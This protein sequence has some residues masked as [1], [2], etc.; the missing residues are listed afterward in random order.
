MRLQDLRAYKSKLSLTAYAVARRLIH[1]FSLSQV[2]TA[3]GIGETEL[4]QLREEIRT[5]T[6]VLIRPKERG[7]KSDAALNRTVS[8]N[9]DRC[10]VCGLLEPHD[11]L[12]T[13][14]IRGEGWLW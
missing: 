7:N 4:R 8:P 13:G 1:G 11:C 6:G 12:H 3:L 10:R 5:V 2:R 9:M 14:N